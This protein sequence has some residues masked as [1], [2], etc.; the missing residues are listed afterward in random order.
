MARRGT[1]ESALKELKDNGMIKQI[2][3]ERSTKYIRA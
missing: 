3:G 1:I 2:G